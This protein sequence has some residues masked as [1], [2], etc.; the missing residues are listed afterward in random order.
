MAI[1]LF[2]SSLSP[3]TAARGIQYDEALRLSKD[4]HTV[5]FLY[6]NGL[7]T[8][9]FTNMSGNKAICR[10]CI[11]N[12]KEERIQFAGKLNFIPLT[13]LVDS[14]EI[15]SI[16]KNKFE[17]RS[18]DDIKN[19]KYNDVNIGLGALSGYIS[20]T[21]NMSPLI[22]EDFKYF[23]DQNLYNSILTIESVTKAIIKFKPDHIVLYN[24]RFS[25]SRPV[26]Q[27][28][29]KYNIP[30][31]TLEA[32]YGLNRN[33]KSIYHNSI[34][35]SIEKSTEMINYY[36]NTSK[37]DLINKIKIGSSFFEKRKNA[38]YSGDK[39]YTK[40]QIKNLLP[41]KWNSTKKNIV[42]FN[43]SEDEFAAIGDEFDK[44][45]LFNSQLEGL[46]FIKMK[47]ESNSNINITL[48][49][50]PNLADI[51]YSYATDL[52]K[53]K[54]GNF[55]VIEADSN[56]STYALL[57]NSDIVVVFGSTVGI[58]SVYWN[59]PTILLAGAGYYNLGCCYIPNSTNELIEMLLSELKPKNRNQS[60]KYGY[61]LVNE[62]RDKHDVI[63][64]NWSRVEIFSHTFM[65]REITINHWKKL[66]NSR[67]LYRVYDKLTSKLFKYIYNFQKNRGTR[68]KIPLKED[69]SNDLH[70]EM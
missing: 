27:L 15:K 66:L 3:D 44:Y 63:D 8:Q 1:Y 13:S 28:A 62:E 57:D 38:K 67:K 58:E 10:K 52:L 16:R 53:L 37:L 30:Y 35:H 4:G 32:V 36:W 42:I 2:H 70:V 59:K 25:D 21:R 26:W 24:G 51:K 29:V 49:I 18:I 47:L 43:S 33:F 41:D 60:L 65:K 56:I 22:D 55:D 54:S 50:H 20:K 34:P 12:F 19:L 5:F 7:M 17:Y 45:K 11:L 68:Y 14:S 23:F 31:T 48:R 6:C 69:K 39:I 64:F 61:Y 46:Q 40:N 9:C